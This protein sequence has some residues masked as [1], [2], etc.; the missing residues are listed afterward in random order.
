M[1]AC[2]V[3]ACALAAVPRDSSSRQCGH[4]DALMF[5]SIA[6]VF[7]QLESR[8]SSDQVVILRELIYS[9]GASRICILWVSKGEL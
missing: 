9:L 5:D 7:V 6:F 3:S 2:T 1:P 4:A 8:M